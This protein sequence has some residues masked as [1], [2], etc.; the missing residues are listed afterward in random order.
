[1]AYKQAVLLNETEPGDCPLE[2][3]LD[4]ALTLSLADLK[5]QFMDPQSG[6]VDYRAIG[7]AEAFKEYEDLEA[8][9]HSWLKTRIASASDTSHTIGD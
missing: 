9:G 1:M 4:I 6:R 7:R 3:P 8:R 5:A 2:K